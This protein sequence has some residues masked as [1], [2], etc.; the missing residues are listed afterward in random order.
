VLVF[1]HGRIV[2]R[3]LHSD[4]TQLTDGVYRGFLE[5]QLGHG[6]AFEVTSPR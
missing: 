1:D 3:G 4:L 5:L 6:A 2:E